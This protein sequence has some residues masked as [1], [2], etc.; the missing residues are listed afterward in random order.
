MTPEIIELTTS[1]TFI[2]CAAIFVASV[3]SS[4]TGMA[5]GVLMFAAMGAFIPMRPLIAI[6][7]VVQ[8]FN[9]FFRSLFLRQNICWKMCGPF[10]IGAIIGTTLTTL[11]LVNYVNEFIPLVI[12]ASLIFYTLFKPKHMPDLK[13]ANKHFIWVGVVTGSMGIIAGA[14]DPLL[15]AFFI[16]D[17]LSK[18]QVVAT[19]SF[20]QLITHTL[21]IP[22]F[23][24]LGFAFIDHLEIIA[25]FTLVAV[26]GTKVGIILLGKI[27][28]FIFF[29]AMKIALLL[30]G[31]RVT[32]QIIVLA[33]S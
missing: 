7:G 30:A 10:T 27:N 24:F 8:I 21:K 23:I 31:L 2:V 5:G 26:I 33:F 32:Y 20:M 18:E 12:L 15:G 3:I 16:R 1:S 22:A 14:I 19:K 28:T 25:L 17:D 29:T 4:V 11:F 13:I 9:N 6:H